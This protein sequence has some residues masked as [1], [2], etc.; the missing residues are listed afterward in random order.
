M[1]DARRNVFKKQYVLKVNCKAE[2]KIMLSSE[3]CPEFLIYQA[4]FTI[5]FKTLFLPIQY[6]LDK[7][8]PKHNFV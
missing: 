4:S 3:I 5:A 6:L 7:V 1:R 2:V 8:I